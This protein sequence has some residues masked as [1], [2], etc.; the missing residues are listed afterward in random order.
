MSSEQITESLS[1][2][3]KNCLSPATYVLQSLSVSIKIYRYVYI[4]PP[5]S[6]YSF[7]ARL[8]YAIVSS[9]I[10]ILYIYVY[11]LYASGKKRLNFISSLT[12]LQLSSSRTWYGTYLI[13]V[14]YTGFSMCPDVAEEINI[15]SMQNQ[16]S[17]RYG[18]W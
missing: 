16:C 17:K 9:R 4:M 3:K 2:F 7:I 6:H 11:D 10:Y 5:R 8:A 1:L 15:R 14:Y 12:T 13:P 18:K